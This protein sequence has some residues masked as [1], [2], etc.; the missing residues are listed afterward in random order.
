MLSTAR[1]RTPAAI[2]ETAAHVLAERGDASMGEIAA[3][4][5]V[6]RA[7]LY[8]HFPT[9]EALLEALASE[10]LAELAARIADASLDR[11]AVPEAVQRLLR[12]LLTVGDRYVVLIRERGATLEEK[13]GEEARRLVGAPIRSVFQRG[14]DDGTLRDDLGPDVLVRLFAGLANAALEAALTRTLGVE[15]TAASIASLFL[16]GARRLP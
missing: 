9:R 15:Q 1:L 8:R 12:A 13:G 14:V 2:L 4:A 11:V 7:T 5:G 3:A 10:A 6:G 16:D